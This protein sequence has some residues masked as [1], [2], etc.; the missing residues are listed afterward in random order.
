MKDYKPKDPS[1]KLMRNNG[2]NSLRDSRFKHIIPFDQELPNDWFTIEENFIFFLIMNLPLIS[3]DFAAAPDCKF[4][5]ESM[6]IVFVKEGMTKIQ[7]CKFFIDA[8]N[9]E[10]IKSPLVEH[11]KVKAFRMEPLGLKVND[12]YVKDRGVIMVDGE[13]IPYGN[14]QGEIKPKLANVFAYNK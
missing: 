7:L 1:I 4:D 13:R 6:H 8:E 14:I 3:Y 5:D 10:H 12:T 2:N 11:I 9:G